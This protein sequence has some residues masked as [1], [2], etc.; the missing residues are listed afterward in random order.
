MTN[1]PYAGTLPLSTVRVRP[2][3]TLRSLILIVI[4]LFVGVILFFRWRDADPH[5]VV[6]EPTMPGPNGF[7]TFVRAGSLADSSLGK[8]DLTSPDVSIDQKHI[9][10]VENWETLRMLREGLALPYMAPPPRSFNAGMPYFASFRS[11]ARLLL[12]D[13][14]VKESEGDYAGAAQADLDTMRLGVMMPRG[15]SLIGKIVGITWEAM[16]RRDLW[17]E[18]PHLRA[19]EASDAAS[20]LRTIGGS[21]T[22]WAST[23]QEEKWDTSAALLKEMRKPGWQ[24]ALLD[25][26]VPDVAAKRLLARLRLFPYSKRQIMRSYTAYMDAAIEDARLP[27]SRSRRGR[28]LP[29]DPINQAI[30]PISSLDTFGYAMDQTENS[31]LEVALALHAYD[32]DHAG[33]P[34]RLEDLVPRYLSSVPI[35][36]FGGAHSLRY[37]RDGANYVLY[38]VGPNARDDGGDQSTLPAGYLPPP[39]DRKSVQR[40]SG[41]DIVAGV[42]L[43]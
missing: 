22:S 7:D 2:R 6:P 14:Q 37:Y 20:R 19:A 32:L 12:A 15:S 8:T 39:A 38:S 30:L 3:S 13:A 40:L 11:L 9:A 5:I 29:N 33:Y 23:L 10:V 35:D 26:M 43:Q 25:E 36:P 21:S 27:Y 31:M 17:Q 4:I 1:Q 24:T 28:R 18:V 16:G 42:D 34:G 41:G